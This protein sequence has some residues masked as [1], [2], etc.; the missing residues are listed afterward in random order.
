LSDYNVIARIA[1]FKCSL[2]ENAEGYYCGSLQTAINGTLT[3]SSRS[4]LLVFILRP[5]GKRFLAAAEVLCV[6][7]NGF[8]TLNTQKALKHFVHVGT[9]HTPFCQDSGVLLHKATSQSTCT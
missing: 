2:F 7:Y 5:T 1:F 8:V 6:N 4:R 3:R 9:T